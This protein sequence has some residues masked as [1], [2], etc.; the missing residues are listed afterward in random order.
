M[1]LKQAP[2][3]ELLQPL[4]EWADDMNINAYWV[5]VDC[6]SKFI[7]VCVLLPTAQGTKR[8]EKE[9]STRWQDLV[10]AGNWAR[11]QIS[12]DAGAAAELLE[13]GFRYTLESTGT[14]HLE[15]YRVST[16]TERSSGEPSKRELEPTAQ[17]G[18]LPA[19]E[20]PWETAPAG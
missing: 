17:Q 8:R 4:P 1:S 20:P 6:H 3:E 18:T 7:Q 2:S 9:F 5:G 10:G 19:I 13:R 14:Y 16:S 11:Q 15:Y 12:S